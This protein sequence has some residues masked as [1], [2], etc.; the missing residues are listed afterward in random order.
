MKTTVHLY[1]AFSMIKYLCQGSFNKGTIFW[2]WKNSLDSLLNCQKSGIKDASVHVCFHCFFQ[3]PTLPDLLNSPMCLRCEG[4]WGWGCVSNT[5]K[6]AVCTGPNGLSVY[7]KNLK[8][9][10]KST[11]KNSQERTCSNMRVPVQADSPISLSNISLSPISGKGGSAPGKWWN[12]KGIIKRCSRGRF[13]CSSLWMPDIFMLT[14]TTSIKW[15]GFSPAMWNFPSFM[16]LAIPRVWLL[17]RGMVV[18]VKHFHT[19]NLTGGLQ[20]PCI[21]DRARSIGL[22]AHNIRGYL[23]AHQNPHEMS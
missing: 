10:P 13:L 14:I 18:A 8:K 16:H 15:C 2:C 17:N 3:T 20:V 4:L 7:G 19:C 22:R 23:R 6:L 11:Q 5:L 12:W 1:M 21:G 9:H